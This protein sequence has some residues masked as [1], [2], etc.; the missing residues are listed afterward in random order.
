MNK[1]IT[2][3][4]VCCLLIG[5]GLCVQAADVDQPVTSASK[6]LDSANKFMDRVG[7]KMNG[8]K[9][10][11]WS[12]ERDHRNQWSLEADGV[13]VEVDDASGLVKHAMNRNWDRKEHGKKVLISAEKA[14]E[15][16]IKY[17]TLAGLAVDEAKLDSCKPSSTYV[18]ETG[19]WT[20]RFKRATH[21][22]VYEGDFALVRIDSEDGSLASF[23]YNFDSPEPESMQAQMPME[24]AIANAKDY[25]AKQGIELGSLVSSDLA[26]VPHNDYWEPDAKKKVSSKQ[27]AHRLA[28]VVTFDGP[29]KKTQVWVDAE[30]GLVIG[31]VKSLDINDKK[32]II[33]DV[34]TVNKT[35]DT[36]NITTDL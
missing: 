12:K 15:L 20:V 29:W 34:P 18:G 23:G 36:Q 7:W 33:N 9:K 2:Y 5:T 17:M 31:G 10:M 4:S 25:L 30:T 28:W 13:I 35:E 19:S 27:L 24:T 8:E 14:T 6:S 26:I 21:G 3:I 16:A 32:A 22:Y 11:E 1:V